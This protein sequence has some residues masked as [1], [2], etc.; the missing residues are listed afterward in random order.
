MKKKR[1]FRLIV[2]ILGV[3]LAAQNLTFTSLASETDS[4]VEQ[5]TADY[6]YE[7]TQAE[8]AAKWKELGINLSYKDSYTKKPNPTDGGELTSGTLENALKMINFIRYTAGVASDVELNED[9]TYHA[10]AAAYVDA[11]INVLTHE[12]GKLYY[13]CSVRSPQKSLCKKL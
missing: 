7:P 8:L 11:T 6:Y 1:V 4:T 12:P 3:A 5:E 2:G 10:Q 9:Y 13:Q